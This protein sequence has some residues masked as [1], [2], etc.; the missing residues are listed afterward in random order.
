MAR[1]FITGA[2]GPAGIALL[3]AAHELGHEVIAGDIDPYA[4]GLYLVE[5]AHRTLLPRGDDPD[6]VDCL[7]G[8]CR[9]HGVDILVPTVDVEL[10]PVA[11]A[12]HRFRNAGVALALSP[13]RALQTCLDKAAL[14]RAAR[15]VLPCPRTEVLRPGLDLSPF[16]GAFVLKPRRGSGS[17]G[18]H[19]CED[20]RLPG[21]IPFDGS[22]LVQELL[23]GAEYSVD[24]FV[25]ASGTA[26]AAVVRERLKVDSGVAV[27]SR[28]VHDEALE[29]SATAAAEAVGI[30]GVCN[31]QLRRN[32]DGVGALLE[33]NPRFPGT[34][35]LSRAAGVDL[36]ALAFAIAQGKPT[37][38]P[39]RFRE[40]AMIRTFAE[41]WVTPATITALEQAE[42]GG[43][44]PT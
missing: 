34:M 19:V 27:V 6:L 18:I 5:E 37:P 22:Y 17:R 23:P 35:P 31:V 44:A 26:I 16:G 38:T 30:R 15:D 2:G 43:L 12:A 13:L 11:Q 7:L 20:G 33:I 36:P 4:A 25:D 39:P 14:A 42:I 41:H 40:I 3:Q 28:T 32:R 1:I 9:Q 29:A 21:G 24:T 8:L 10:I